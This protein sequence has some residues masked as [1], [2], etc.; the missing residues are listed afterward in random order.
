MSKI[1]DS[2]MIIVAAL[3]VLLSAAGVT[4]GAKNRASPA[5]EYGFDRTNVSYI[6]YSET[7][8]LEGT[9]DTLYSNVYAIPR[10]EYFSLSVVL[11]TNTTANSGGVLPKVGLQ[12]AILS[13]NRRFLLQDD[14]TS[15]W[16]TLTDSIR[17]FAD[18]TN[19]H[20]NFDSD[21]SGN[22]YGEI[23]TVAPA[24]CIYILFRIYT[25]TGHAAGSVYR[26]VM[27]FFPQ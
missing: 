8:S 6:V 22:E 1:K 11:D 27:E 3:V 4:V 13:T 14:S 24:P 18:F 26:Y 25:A 23:H 15:I 9:A 17:S 12:Y 2:K 19:T 16:C 21:L 7:D 5:A 10:A 20:A